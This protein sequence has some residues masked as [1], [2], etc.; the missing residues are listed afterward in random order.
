MVV[1]KTKKWLSRE[2]FEELLKISDYLGYDQEYKR[3]SINVEKAFR[4]GYTL[5]DIEELIKDLSLEVEGSLESLKTYFEALT[6]RLEWDSAKGMIKIH[7][8]KGAYYKLRNILS[9]LGAYKSAETPE[10][11]FFNL[12]PHRLKLLVEQ[13]QRAGISFEDPYKLT[14]EKPLPFKPEL[15]NIE[16]RDYQKE[17]LEKWLSNNGQGIIALPTGAGKTIIAIAAL[18][19]RP[20]KTLIIVYTKEQM[21]Q[22]K[23]FITKS[24]NLP[25]SMVGLVYSESKQLAPVTVTTYQSGFRQINSIS[26]FFDQLIVDEVHHLPAD[27]FRYIAIHS[28]ARYRMGLSATPVREDGRH[29]ELFPLLGG[30]IYYKTPEELVEKGY[31]ARYVIKTIR[32]KMTPEEKKE[33]TQLRNQY[34]A[35]AKGRKFEEVVEDASRGDPSAIEALRVHSRIKNLLAHSETKINKAIEIAMR[36]LEKGSKIIIFTQFVDQAEKI[37]EK[38]GGFLLTGEIPA[39]ERKRALEAFKKADKGVLVV[40]TVGDEGLDIPD[41]NVGILVSGTGS[42]RQFIQRLGR[43]LRPG[44]KEAVL[45]ELVFE[46]TSEEYQAYKRKRLDLDLEDEE[47]S[48]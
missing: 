16:L 40:T 4:N 19:S 35:L 18:V 9:S 46:K 1:V 2:E 34:L 38:L 27:K 13:S 37:A 45:Y 32:V 22:W 17:A 14:S 42:R 47:G 8:P 11:L 36:E 30:I 12:Y 43:L 21:F 23:D 44:K 39:S 3:F 26:P 15:R 7:V 6:P 41:A 20:V 33:Y 31:L 29:E 25:S 24:T 5:E 10:A 28:I 48:S